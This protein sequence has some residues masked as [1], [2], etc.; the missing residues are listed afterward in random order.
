[1]KHFKPVSRFSYV[2]LAVCLLAFTTAGK[3]KPNPTRAQ[4]QPAAR[5][6]TQQAAPVAKKQTAKKQT[7]NSEKPKIF[8]SINATTRNRSLSKETVLIADKSVAALPIVIAPGAT[9]ETQAQAQELATTLQKISGATFQIKEGGTGPAIFL[10]TIKEFPTAS[11][12]A[13]LE[14]VGDFDGREAFAIR[15]EGKS[16][17]LIGATAKAM[18]F[19]VTRFLEELGCRWFFQSPAWDVLPKTSRLTFNL[20]ETDRPEMLVRYFGYPRGDMFEK[21]DPNAGEALRTWWRHNYVGKSFESR[22]GHAVPAIRAHFKA[23]FEAHPEYTALV[24]GKRTPGPS[25]QL[26]ISNPAVQKLVSEYANDYFEKNPDAEMVGVGPDDGGGN[27]ECPVCTKLWPNPGD[28]AFFLANVAAKAVQKTHPGKFVGIYAYNWHCDPPPFPMEQNVYIELTSAM[29]LNT[30]YSFDELM[31]LWPKKVRY[32][33]VYDYW[34]V[35]DWTRDHLPS[36]R[37]S[38]TSYV[39]HKLPEYMHHGICSLVSEAGTSWGGQGLGYYLASRVLWNSSVDT[40]AL[41]NDFYEKAFGP[42]AGDMKTYYTR[43]DKANGPLAGPTFYRLAIDDLDRAEKAAQGDAEVLNR[44]KQLKQYHVY[45]YLFNKEAGRVSEAEK[46]QT[47]YDM[48]KWNYRIRNN[49]MIFWDFFADQVT[50][51]FSW[52]YG[53]NPQWNFSRMRYEGKAD[54]IPYRDDPTEPTL[55]ETNKVLQQAKAFYGEPADMTETKWSNDFVVPEWKTERKIGDQLI[56]LQGDQ[57]LLLEGHADQPLRFTLYHAT[58]YENK[59]PGTYTL[60]DKNGVVITTGRVPNGEHNFEAKV[61]RN[62]VYFLRYEDNEAGWGFR[63]TPDVRSAFLLE[64][65]DF[66]R[67]NARRGTFAFYVPKGTKEIRMYANSHSA[68]QIYTPF[69]NFKSIG[70]I[71]GRREGEREISNDGSVVTIPVPEGADGK[72]WP[73]QFIGG[74]FYFFNIPNVI[75]VQEDGPIL[76]REIAEKE[77]LKF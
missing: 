64:R 35:Y 65:K 27:C 49:Y 77:G 41:K 31:D 66:G 54:Q 42:A 60:R 13:G 69:P 7:E 2:T 6:K 57:T 32:V 28:S 39:A 36:G 38:D 67:L 61:P 47:A 21:T 11:A 48:M 53:D 3:A 20:N 30:K 25:G 51:R 33:G 71:P 72:L 22:T 40:Q 14:I 17:R 26:C 52:Q 45:L 68:V 18:P 19:A 70:N 63:P 12:T 29:L 73:A 62:E 76:P 10:G 34:A 9:T 75:L 43:V 37:T 46:K 5:A 44:I 4:A 50:R 23:E 8:A 59:A 24:N 55:E 15:T 1:M 74:S 56:L 58:V 16:I